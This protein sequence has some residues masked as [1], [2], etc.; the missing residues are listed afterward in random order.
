MRDWFTDYSLNSF[1]LSEN[2]VSCLLVK[3]QQNE[4]PDAKGAQAQVFAQH[5]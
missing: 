5:P 1:P 4:V 2:R 3:P